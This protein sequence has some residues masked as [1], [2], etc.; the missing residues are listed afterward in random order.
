MSSSFNYWLAKVK[1][2]ED[3]LKAL[4]KAKSQEKD[5]CKVCV[6]IKRAYL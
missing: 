5:R 4:E 3:S 2:K 1:E 6:K